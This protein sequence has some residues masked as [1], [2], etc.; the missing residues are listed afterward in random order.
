MFVQVYTNPF[1]G[2]RI[3]DVMTWEVQR[4]VHYNLWNKL[5][6]IILIH[7]QPLISDEVILIK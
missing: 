2:E 1:I 6:Q 5:Y 4:N 7:S 3:I